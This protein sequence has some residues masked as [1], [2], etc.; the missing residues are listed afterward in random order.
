MTRRRDAFTNTFWRL[1]P[2]FVFLED[3][4]TET[5]IFQN[6]DSLVFLKFGSGEILKKL[7][8]GQPVRQFFASFCF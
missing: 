4:K 3:D 7:E 6:E 2:Y 1:T 8:V 5:E